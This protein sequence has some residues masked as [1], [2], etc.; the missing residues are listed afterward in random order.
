MYFFNHIIEN[1]GKILMIVDNFQV[2]A[3]EA[4]PVESLDRSAAQDALSKA[5]QE[6]NSASTEI[7]SYHLIIK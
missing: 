3:E 2:L 4:H 5:Q 6:L 7:V 1:C